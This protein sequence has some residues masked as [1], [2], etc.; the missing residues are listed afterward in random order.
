MRQLYKTSFFLFLLMFGIASVSA[1]AQ[2]QPADSGSKKEC[3]GKKH[4]GDRYSQIP[5][6][7][8]EQKTQIEEL[9]DS[10]RSETE[11]I[12]EEIR[13][14]KDALHSL[15]TNDSATTE[16]IDALIDEIG[17]LKTS[18]MKYRVATDKDVRNVL[19][20]EQLEYLDSLPEHPRHHK[21]HMKKG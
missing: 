19:T 17:A 12:K 16:E 9:Q 8:D 7:T 13:E 5:D 1:Y 3:A 2:D 20:D 21:K 18:M 4:R 10:L 6:L 11:P 15:V 14:K